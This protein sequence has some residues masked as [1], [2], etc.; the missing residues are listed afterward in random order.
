MSLGGYWES[1]YRSG[2]VPWDPGP[3]DRHVP[4]V[5]AD[6]RIEPGRA[7]DVGCGTGAT[8]VY[9]ARRGFETTGIDIAP[10]ALEIAR[11][12]AGREGVAG[13]WL[14]GSFPEEFSPE[15]LPDDSFDFVIERGFLHMHTMPQEHAPIL[16]GIQRVLRRGGAFY[17]L[18]AKREGASGFGGPPKWREDEIRR[19]VE[20]YF[21]IVEMRGDVFTPEEAGSM[22]AWVT[23]MRPH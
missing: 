22:P 3:Y 5:L 19:A 12:T 4:Q 18:A 10:T 9:L 11:R 16:A 14:V 17:S 2:H 23:V 13:N 1:S 8:L 6:H 7:L 15:V 21:R 20:P